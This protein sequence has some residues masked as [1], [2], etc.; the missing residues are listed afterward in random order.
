MNPQSLVKFFAIL[1]SFLCEIK[2]DIFRK[3]KKKDYDLPKG[4]MSNVVDYCVT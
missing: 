3:K 1:L 4:K 2:Y